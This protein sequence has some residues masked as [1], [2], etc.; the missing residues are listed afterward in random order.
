MTI[1]P[2]LATRLTLALL[3]AYAIARGYY[4]LLPAYTGDE[5]WFLPAAGVYDQ[6][7]NTLGWR[8]LCE[9]D[10]FLAYGALHW[11]LS[12]AV[13]SWGFESGVGAGEAVR[14]YSLLCQLAVPA[15]L[16]VWGWRDGK[17]HQ[18]LLALALYVCIPLAWW[19]GKLISAETLSMALAAAGAAL[20]LRD[21]SRIR[22]LSWLLLG[23]ALGVKLSVLPLA[24]YVGL[25]LLPALGWGVVT[26]LRLGKIASAAAVGFVFANPFMVCDPLRFVQ[27]LQSNATRSPDYD[28]WTRFKQIL[29]VDPPFNWDFVWNGGILQA[30]LGPI[31][32]LLMGLFLWREPAARR[33]ALPAIGAALLG[34]ALMMG[35]FRYYHWYLIP[36]LLIPPLLVMQTEKLTQVGSWLLIGVI[37]ANVIT[38]HGP[39]VY[40][41]QDKLENVA[42]LRQSD[43]IARCVAQNLRGLDGPLRVY[44]NS[45]YGLNLSRDKIIQWGKTDD[46]MDGQQPT[47]PIYWTQVEE[48]LAQQGQ[49]A[50]ITAHYFSQVRH[51][52]PD[53]AARL[54]DDDGSTRHFLLLVGDRAERN[55]HY[56]EKIQQRKR[57]IVAGRAAPQSAQFRCGYVQ[58]FVYR[59]DDR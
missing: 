21:P 34:W 52:G 12:G 6:L 25:C 38:N 42:N 13:G 53:L 7:W 27:N 31:S 23:M 18:T 46:L 59:W 58:G 51:L 49:S 33:W 43:A 24:A 54:P 11:I 37:G 20:A 36:I 16:V 29:Y 2:T 47:R 3:L 45:D 17:P 28:A 1:S 10:N 5:A 26:L 56:L 30:G 40:L 22:A 39:I 14:V 4:F 55:L 44:D 32:L 15:A 9:I 35:L 50:P 41:F 8:A 19:D 57:L 48:L